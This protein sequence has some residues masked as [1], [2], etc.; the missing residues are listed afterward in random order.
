M[1]LD[2][3]AKD[4]ALPGA[5]SAAGGAAPSILDLWRRNGPGLLDTHRAEYRA[6]LAPVAP[7]I[8]SGRF[9]EA[10][11]AAQVAA[12]H[13]VLWHHGRFACPELEDALARIGAAALPHPGSPR[14]A[15]TGRALN[16]LHVATEVYAIGGHSRLAEQWM[17]ED[18]ASRHSLV[19]TRQRGPIPATTT[20]AVSAA[21]GT[22]VVLNRA[23][24]ILLDWAGRLQ[25]EMARA[26]VVVLHVHSMDVLPFI[27]CAGMARRPP[28]LFVNHSDH[29]FFVG[30]RFADLVVC[31]RRSGHRLCIDRRG[32][33]AERL[34]LLPLCLGEEAPQADRAAARATLGLARD[35]VMIL[36]VARGVKFAPVGHEAFPDP[37]VELLQRNPHVR[38]VAVGPGGEVDW[39]A[40]EAAVPGRIQAI[41][42]TRETARYFAAADIYLDSFPFVSITSLLE[43]GRAGLPMV[44]RNPFGPD[45]AVMGADT[46]GFDA[47]IVRSSSTAEMVATLQRLI[48][49]AALRRQIGEAARTVIAALNGGVGWRRELATLH[50]RALALPATP[51]PCTPDLGSPSDLDSFLP[52]VY[53]DQGRGATAASR[54]EA[55]MGASIKAGPLAWRLRS[56]AELRRHGVAPGRGQVVRWCTPEWVTSRLRDFQRR[57]SRA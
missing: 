34:A 33:P 6:L 56:V 32:I 48:D 13:A 52:F 14:T 23:A 30:A 19:L 42:A 2:K 4:G 16:V 22:D 11:A 24:G 25:S 29:L 20:D 12:N 31:T 9:S 53:G 28:M 1:L 47:S 39:S 50:A 41:T 18:G 10:T 49:D 45:C 8:A 3:V 40:A 57:G 7:L 21:G 15:A 44:T 38:L 51:P 54:L 43:A 36:T 27:A 37:F 35:D 46:I 26:D 55:A 5:A 17:R